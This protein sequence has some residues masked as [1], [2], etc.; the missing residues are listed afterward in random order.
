MMCNTCSDPLGKRTENQRCQNDKIGMC[1]RARV[2]VAKS[3]IEG[4]GWGLF[5][6]E[7][8]IK[9]DFVDE[10]VGEL[11]SQEEADRRGI[12]YDQVN[13][14][15]LFNVTT[16][17]VLDASRKGNKARFANHSDKANCVTKT[18]NVNGDLRIGLFAKEDI[19]PQSEVSQQVRNSCF[20][21]FS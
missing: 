20:M 14:S 7:A 17:H 9:G 19:P 12:V 15:Y 10:Y 6:K 13:R 3:T 18:V 1:R 2:I 5:N 16:D 4:A 8:L 11:I 21:I